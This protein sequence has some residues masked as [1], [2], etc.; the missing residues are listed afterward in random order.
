MY[1]DANSS[2]S[3]AMSKKLPTGKFLWCNDLTA[4]KIENPAKLA[5][6]EQLIL[7]TTIESDHFCYDK[8]RY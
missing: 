2:Y 6:I 5:E 7:E 8:M 3:A 4:A 1:Y